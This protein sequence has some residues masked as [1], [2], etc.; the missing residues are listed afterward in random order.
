MR[1]IASFRFVYGSTPQAAAERDAERAR[2]VGLLRCVFGHS[3]RPT[4]CDPSWRSSTG[5]ALTAGIYDEPALGDLP[6]LADALEEAG[7]T[8]PSI[9]GHLRGPG[10]HVRGCWALDLILGKE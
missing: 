2:L 4:S 3:V 9:L 7:C 5:F 8:D 6:I 10:P 1:S